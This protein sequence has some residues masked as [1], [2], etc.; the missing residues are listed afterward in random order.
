VQ[1]DRGLQQIHVQPG[2]S[3]V[4]REPGILCTLLG[5]CVGITFWVSRLQ[6]G[7]LCHPMLPVIPS[8]RGTETGKA[9]GRRYVDFTIR[10]LASQL[11]ALGATREETE[12]KLFGGADVLDMDRSHSRPTV[13]RLNGEAA[14][15]ILRAEGYKLAASRLGG[16][17][18]MQIQFNTSNGEVLLRSLGRASK[19]VHPH[20]PRAVKA[21]AEPWSR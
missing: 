2:E 19:S 9:S 8:R 13:G 10:D 4:I 20:R 21:K 6:V 5:S 11:D 3:H 17:E 18:G 1:R 14:E 12:V 16:N 7:A 15:R